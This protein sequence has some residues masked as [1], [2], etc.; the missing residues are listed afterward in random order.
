LPPG[1]LERHQA[2]LLSWI[3]DIAPYGILTTDTNLRVR[4]WNEWLESH[5]GLAAPL[6]IGRTI[7]EIF[8]ELVERR[9]LDHFNHA[10]AGEVIVL[11][12]TFHDYLLPF[13]STVRN[14]GLQFMK[15]TARI[16]PLLLNDE[17]CGTVVV[18]E[19]VTHRV[20]QS[21]TLA[22]QHQRAELL[23]TSLGQLLAT[24][25]SG[26]ALR[27]ILEKVA[28]FLNLDTF[29]FYKC[30]PETGIL[31]LESSQGFTPAQEKEMSSVG[32][33]DSPYGAAATRRH[34]IL[35]NMV[36]GSAEPYAARAR[37]LGLRAM[38]S[39]PLL[40]ADRLLGVLSFGTRTREVLTVEQIELIATLA[41]YVAVSIDR[42]Q[43]EHELR[44]TQE[45]LSAH[46][47]ELET[48]VQERTAKL[49]DTI[50]QLESFSYTVAHD[51]RAPIRA[52]KGYSQVLL[53]ED[54]ELSAENKLYVSR[55]ER[56]ASRLE[57]LTRDL[58]Q[59][60]TLS[61]QDVEL[62]SVPLAELIQDIRLLRP[63]LHEDILF[64]REPLHHVIGH[65]T[66]LQQC[67]S[68]LLDNAVKFVQP[69]VK[70]K[71]VVFSEI[72][73]QP[74]S[75]AGEPVNRAFNPAVY[76]VNIQSASPG[77]IVAPEERV[78]VWVEDN[79][80]GIPRESHEKVFGI[81]ERLNSGDKFEGT[82]IGLAIVARAMQRMGG[83]CGVESSPGQG[84]RFWLDFLPA[85]G[86]Q[87]RQ[88]ALSA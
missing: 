71:I 66:L 87:A 76:E 78:R 75:R 54:N 38:V 47:R 86:A 73:T 27:E 2:A 83:R 69:D 59:F 42:S 64:V 19:D 77:E 79:G 23:S 41:Q 10:L 35:L 37:S 46:A 16:A 5:S 52:L 72:I 58:L 55:I 6:V 50:V 4:T 24:D 65:R 51:L 39:H 56:S 60:S 8:P 25:D 3:Q 18:I 68:N 22:R 81:F 57:M 48:R 70:P 74:P 13:P 17:C 45:A 1:P 61:R 88:P 36:Q 32:G 14:S 44:Q 30:H 82:G 49:Q 43:R 21:A 11:S 12:A 62:S 34:P 9:M 7:P 15:Q 84:S 40:A 31:E 63:S 33:L 85:P 20:V 28:A 67:L 29:T 26:G 80:I 53:S